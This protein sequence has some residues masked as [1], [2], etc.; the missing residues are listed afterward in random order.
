M[1]R[2]ET[3]DLGQLVR[4][5]GLCILCVSRVTRCIF[6]KIGQ[7]IARP[8]FVKINTE[9]LSRKKVA[10]KI[11]TSVI[12]KKLPKEN[13]RPMGEN[14]PKSGHSADKIKG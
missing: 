14:S 8:F 7:N 9:H 13:N 1:P 4:K 12:F 3:S 10:Q 2:H 11:A 5:T 6:E